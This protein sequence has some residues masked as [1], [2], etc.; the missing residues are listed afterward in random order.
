MKTKILSHLNNKSTFTA[1]SN[2]RQGGTHSYTRIRKFS[3]VNRA[4]TTTKPP[5]STPSENGFYIPFNFAED[6]T[7]EFNNAYT[8]EMSKFRRWRQMRMEKY[9]IEKQR[10]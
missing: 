5:K 4:Q 2:G 3:R 9:T 6:N 1:T 8:G 10:K 7:I